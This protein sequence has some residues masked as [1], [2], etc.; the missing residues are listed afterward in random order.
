MSFIAAAIIGSGVIG[1]GASLFS[2]F[3]QAGAEK[4][5][6]QTIAGAETSGIG[7]IQQLLGPII[8]A[9]TD[10]LPTLKSLLI[11]GAN[12]NAVLAQ[13]PGFQFAQQWGQIAGNNAATTSGLGGNVLAALSKFGTGLAQ[14]T[15]QNTVQGLQNLFQTSAGSAGQ[16]AQGISNIITGAGS[17]IA[18]TQVG[19]AT[20]LGAGATGAASALSSPLS[21][22]T[23][24][25]LLK[26]LLQGGSNAGAFTDTSD[27]TKLGS[28]H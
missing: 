7:A 27:P 23:N 10:V 1:A 19:G 6:A 12:Q 11:P 13:T 17:Q 18:Q 3:E 15:W 24:F 26:N 16:G 21:T 28:L 14:N 8:G 5:A 4:Q 9:G 20:A 22:L 2:G 25:A